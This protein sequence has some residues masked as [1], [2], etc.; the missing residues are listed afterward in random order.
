M[1]LPNTVAIEL[2]LDGPILHIWLNRPD[3]KNAMNQ[4]MVNE[5]M[6]VFAAIKDDAAIRGVILRGR[7]GNFCAG[8]DIK[9][10]AGIRMQ[11]AEVGNI[12]P[13]VQFNRSFGALIEAVDQAPQVVVAVVEG[14][15]LGGGFGL[16]CV[17]DVAL[18]A[19]DAQFGLP[20]TGLGV[21][22]AQIAPFVVQRIG[23]TQTR[24]LALLGNRFRGA[25]A[26][27]LGLVH[28]MFDDEAM[29]DQAVEQVKKQIRRTAPNAN[30]VTKAL[31]HRVGHEPMG[32]LLDDAAQLFAE[33]VSGPE[34][35]EG[36][37]AFVQKR[38]P[39]WTE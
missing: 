26:V 24:R 22:P 30:R 33:A 3:S 35:I 38:L 25:E 10:M 2:K 9:D 28:E 17:S 18:A 19:E 5:L 15:V 13:Y 32:S 36:T 16:A 21:I 23:L 6:Q 29:L 20:E 14:A 31:L 37:M 34:G 4:Q 27:R 12:T 8:A 39:N 1:T 11:V 7:G